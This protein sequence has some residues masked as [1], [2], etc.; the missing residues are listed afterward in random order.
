MKVFLQILGWL[1]CVVYSTIPSFWFM[2]H[3]FAERWRRRRSPFLVLVPAWILMWIAL[4]LI[5]QPWHRMIL[6]ATPWGWSFAIPLFALGLFLYSRSGGSFSAKHLGG[7]PEVDGSH[8]QQQLVTNGL[9]SRVR[10]PVYLAHL[11]EMLAWSVGTGLVVCWA[12]TTFA[13]LTGMIMIQ[14]EDKELEQRFG[15]N[16]RHYRDSVPAVL[17]RFRQSRQL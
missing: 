5:T 6:Y 11:C 8:R 17:P 14:M 13:I 10:H 7:L 1:A 2:I 16:F 15:D 12:L 9:R 4:I 3:P